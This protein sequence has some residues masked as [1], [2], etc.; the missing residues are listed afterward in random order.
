MIVAN[1]DHPDVI[2]SMEAIAERISQS[3]QNPDLREEILYQLHGLRD[4]WASA[5]K[6]N[7]AGTR[8]QFKASSRG[9]TTVSLLKNIAQD[10]DD[11]FACLNS[12]RNVEP[13]SALI[14][15]DQAPDNESD[16]L[17][18]PFTS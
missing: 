1:F 18:E 11:Y 14:F 3:F 8:L 9:G 12:L 15:V 17:L 2:A 13:A 7:E 4:K 5:A 16:R 6:P 10:P